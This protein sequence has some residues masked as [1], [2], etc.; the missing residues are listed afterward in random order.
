MGAEPGWYVDPDG[1]PGRQRWWDGDGWGDLTQGGPA[2][3]GTA[4]GI[5]DTGGYWAAGQSDVITAP[6]PP[7]RDVLATPERSR[8]RDRPGRVGALLVVGAIVV[9]IALAVSLVLGRSG[10]STVAGPTGPVPSTSPTEDPG[11]FPPGTVRI[12]D[13]DAG[14]SYAYLG[15]GW[16]ELD[17][18]QRPEMITAHGQYIVTQETTPD[19]GEFVAECSSGPLAEQFEVGGPDSYASIIEPLSDSYRANYYP[20]PNERNV[21]SS[22]AVTLDGAAG[23]LLEFDLTW[24]VAGYE[25]TGERVALLLLDTGR[26][27]P[28]VMYVSIP[29]THAELYGVIDDLVASVLVLS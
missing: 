4:Y 17:F 6:A 12:L 18:A 13:P 26:E 11:G 19:G 21:L 29:N 14:L 23:Y 3:Y 22:E 24:D 7:S 1:V 25:S 20:A 16:R 15:E 2:T 9:I 10:A 5:P 28:A 8:W 27:R